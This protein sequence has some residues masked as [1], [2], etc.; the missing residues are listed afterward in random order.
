[1][2]EKHSRI[3]DWVK[4][5]LIVEMFHI[6]LTFKWAVLTKTQGNYSARGLAKQN[7]WEKKILNNSNT[8]TDFRWIELVLGN[9]VC[10]K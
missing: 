3:K 5:Y 10:G 2:K 1:M 6:K 9:W 8:G 7:L 4:K